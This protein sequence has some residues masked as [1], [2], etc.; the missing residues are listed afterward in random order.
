M[1]HKL[2]VGLE[3]IGTFKMLNVE[4]KWTATNV[5]DCQK[6]KKGHRVVNK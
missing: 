1:I 2:E 3:D 4:D 6:I 5:V